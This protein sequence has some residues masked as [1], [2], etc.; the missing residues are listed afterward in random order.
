M[1]ISEILTDIH[2]LEGNVA[3]YEETN[4]NKRADAIDFIDFHILDRIEGLL[5]NAALKEELNILKEQAEK[6]KSKLEKIDSR[7]F[8]NLRGKI[9]TGSCTKS[10]FREM[11]GKHIGVDAIGT[12]LP[13]GIGYD[14]LDIFIN[15]LLFDNAIPEPAITPGPEMVFYQKTPARVI[16]QLTQLAELT[17]HDVFFDIGS[18]LGQA[19]ILVNLLSGA[20][21]IGIEFEPA[22]TNYAK[23]C[24]AQF[25]LNRVEFINADALKGDYSQGTVFFLYTPFEGNML[26]EM[27]EI[28]KREAQ[29]RPVRIFTYGPCS[30]TVALHSWLHCVNGTADDFYKLYEFRSLVD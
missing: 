26:Q 4:F 2:S 15:G 24:A 29:K 23:T 25:N 10:A 17:E 28:L 11:I 6:L 1:I 20:K 7:L 13:D 9:R 5:Q 14:N 12:A 22:Y 27:M 30:P 16:F 18:G 21:A 3:L 8:A 19:V